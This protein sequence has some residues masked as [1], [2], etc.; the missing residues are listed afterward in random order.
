MTTSTSLPSQHATFHVQEKCHKKNERQWHGNKTNLTCFKL[1]S[2]ARINN[3][4]K[5]IWSCWKWLGYAE[6]DQEKA[7]FC[8]LV[9]EF[10]ILQRKRRSHNSQKA[11]TYEK[12]ILKMWQN[13]EYRKGSG[14]CRV[15]HTLK[16]FLHHYSAL[17]F[18]NP[19]AHYNSVCLTL[20]AAFPV[21]CIFTCWSYSL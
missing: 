3:I 17:Y 15:P 9:I 14:L 6:D 13:L 20:Q 2:N 1:V 4:N 19:Y 8:C 16:W 21:L 7:S 10:Y 12:L 18:D 11:K 5:E